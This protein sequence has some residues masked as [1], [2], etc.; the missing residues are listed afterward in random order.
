MLCTNMAIWEESDYIWEDNDYKWLSIVY[1]VT[2]K[3]DWYDAE[4][5][6]SLDSNNT[7]KQ[8]HHSRFDWYI[9]RHE[10]AVCSFPSF[11]SN[12]YFR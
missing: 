7:K 12:L 9:V 10:Y 8:I 4:Q 3:C 11:I 5:H 6:F 1:Q 2:L